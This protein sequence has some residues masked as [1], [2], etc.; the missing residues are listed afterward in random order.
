[1]SGLRLETAYYSYEGYED[2][3]LIQVEEVDWLKKID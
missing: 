3:K 1:M 2:F